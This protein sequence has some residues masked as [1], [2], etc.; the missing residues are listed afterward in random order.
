MTEDEVNRYLDAMERDE[1][2]RRNEQQRAQSRNATVE[3]DW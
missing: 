1:R 3:R 2:Q